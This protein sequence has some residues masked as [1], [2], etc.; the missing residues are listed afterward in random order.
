M[1]TKNFTKKLSLNKATVS[2]LTNEEQIHLMGGGTT[3][4]N[5][6]CETCMEPTVCMSC[7]TDVCV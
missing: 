6:V 1:K 4:P 7:V 2:H 5:T 3:R